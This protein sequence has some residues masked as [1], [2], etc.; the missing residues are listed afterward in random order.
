MYYNSHWALTCNWL[1][2]IFLTLDCTLSNI[3]GNALVDPTTGSVSY[4]QLEQLVRSSFGWTDYEEVVGLELSSPCGATSRPIRNTHDV[5]NVL[6]SGPLDQDNVAVISCVQQAKS[7]AGRLAQRIWNTN[8]I[9]QGWALVLCLLL[10]MIPATLY[11]RNLFRSLESLSS[12][13][14]HSSTPSN[15]VT[16]REC[17][18]ECPLPDW[19]TTLLRQANETRPTRTMTPT[20]PTP[21]S[22]SQPQTQTHQAQ[23]QEESDNLVPPT[24][25]DHLV[26]SPLKA[27]LRGM[28]CQ[29]RMYPHPHVLFFHKTNR[30]LWKLPPSLAPGRYIAKARVARKG[31]GRTVVHA[32]VVSLEDPENSGVYVEELTG[33][34]VSKA[35]Y[36][37]NRLVPVELPATGGWDRFEWQTLALVDLAK[38]DDGIQ[39][40]EL[41]FVVV[42][43]N[44]TMSPNVD[45][46]DIVLT[47]L[48]DNDDDNEAASYH[49][50]RVRHNE[51]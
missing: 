21:E 18:C 49:W 43:G 4:E 14:L 5:Q 28:H 37:R 35:G 45:F 29:V 20:H 42:A 51:L 40:D 47:R 1:L 34:V 2:L 48:P 13:W 17:T 44:G 50:N 27:T 36:Y 3:P 8:R 30:A 41:A 26:L 6:R 7:P 9:R 19:I 33:L 31:P 10:F 11:R 25:Q 15:S 38:D 24:L 12:S 32:G 39:Q 23:P 22:S 46:Q 16:H